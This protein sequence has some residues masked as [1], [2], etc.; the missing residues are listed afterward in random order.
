MR[1][2]QPAKRT[3]EPPRAAHHRRYNCPHGVERQN[4]RGGS[5]ACSAPAVSAWHRRSTNHG[6][7]VQ[8]GGE[9]VGRRGKKNA[10]ANE[11]RIS[12]PIR[13]G[14][15]GV[16]SILAALSALGALVLTALTVMLLIETV[17]AY[18]RRGR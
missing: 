16:T 15:R 11:D 2:L 17:D 8:D 18:Y 10:V 1:S 13:P 6:V 3:G 12:R 14:E 4:E 5:M 9:G 7:P